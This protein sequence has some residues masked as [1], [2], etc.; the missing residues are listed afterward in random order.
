MSTSLMLLLSL[1]VQVMAQTAGLMPQVSHKN[2]GTALSTSSGG[3][4]TRCHNY[5]T[6]ALSLLGIELMNRNL[7]STPAATCSKSTWPHEQGYGANVSQHQDLSYPFILL[8]RF[9]A[10]MYRI[11]TARIKMVGYCLL[12]CFSL[13]CGSVADTSRNRTVPLSTIKDAGREHGPA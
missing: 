9:V 3:I 8:K 6:M 4:S 1:S 12:G 11:A 13:K 2:C 10:D 7:F 5:F